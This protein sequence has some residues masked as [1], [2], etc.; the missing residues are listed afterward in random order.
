[1][2]LQR[3]GNHL[4]LQQ[5]K[6]QSQHK[7]YES[8]RIEVPIALATYS[9]NRDFTGMSSTRQVPVHRH[10]RGLQGGNGRSCQRDRGQ[11]TPAPV[12][13]KASPDAHH[14]LTTFPQQRVQLIPKSGRILK[15]RFY[16]ERE[17]PSTFKLIPYNRAK[18]HFHPALQQ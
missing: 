2:A 7:Y 8:A 15:S 17:T 9:V 3:T 5:E 10:Q 4:S 14:A 18:L 6:L 12:K 1:M 11:V 13:S 16:F